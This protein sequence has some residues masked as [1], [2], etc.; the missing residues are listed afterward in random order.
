MSK[1]V[2]L[3]LSIGVLGGIAAWAFLSVGGILIWAAFIGWACFFHMG[4]DNNALRNTIVGNIF[5]SVCAWI[6]AII[7]LA[8]PL[9]DKLTVPLWAGIVVGVTV[10]AICYAATIKAFS[11][12]PA[13]VYGYAATFAFLLQTPDTLS[14]SNLLSLSFGNAVIAVS[15][16]MAIGAVLGL[17]SAKGA[18]AI[19]SSA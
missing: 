11:S 3:S 15:V 7:I 6:A 12:I 10:W 5:G 18:A 13:N 16:S 4:G 2:A 9:A 8:V 14:L 1:M 17:A 19:G